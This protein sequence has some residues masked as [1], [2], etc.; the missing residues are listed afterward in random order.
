M[1]P[2]LLRPLPEK[3]DSDLHPANIVV[4]GSRLHVIDFD[5]SGFGW[6]HYDIA[7]ALFNYHLDNPIEH[8]Q[9]AM[10]AGYRKFRAISDNDL[11]YLRVFMLI[12]AMVSIGWYSARPEVTAGSIAL[13]HLI[14]YVRS[15]AVSVMAS[16]GIFIKPMPSI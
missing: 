10:I 14:D 12:R 13:P 3:S 1:T 8:L 11:A 16:H 9:A 15:N 2:C 6:H 4:E 7:V 5:D